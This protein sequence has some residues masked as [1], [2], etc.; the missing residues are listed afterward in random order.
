MNHQPEYPL[1][2]K[3][4]RRALFLLWGLGF[5]INISAQ[6]L[7]TEQ[8]YAMN[9]PGIVKVQAVFSATVYVNKVDLNQSRFDKL[10]DSVKR[11]DSTGRLF[12]SEQ[13]LDILVRA[14]YKNPLRFF[15]PT[16]EYFKQAHRVESS[17]TGF[18]ITGD[19]YILTNCHII[20]R[21]SAYIRRKFILS[22]FHEVSEAGINAL[23]NSWAME[24]NEQ[25]RNLLNDAYGLIYS[26]LSSLILFDLKKEFFVS[27]RADRGGEDAETVQTTA[28]I[29]RQGQPM[30]GK[31]VAILKIN[32]PHE[33]PALQLS[34]D[35]FIA[36]GTQVL[37]LGYPEPVT[38]HSFLA[39]AAAIEPSL[40]TGIVSAVKTSIHGWPVIQ[41]DA[42]ISHGSSGSPVCNDHGEVIGIATFGSIDAG[43]TS[44]ASG[45][46]FAIPVSVVRDF[47]E[48]AGLDPRPGKSTAL[49]NEGLDLYFHQYYRRALEKFRETALVNVKYPQLS[50]YTDQC[51][52]KVES[53]AGH[54]APPR[55]YVLYFM[56]LLGV[57]AV[58]MI[59]YRT[60]KNRKRILHAS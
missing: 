27:Y 40:T 45:F 31:D 50:F 13:K 54:S 57:G 60:R 36:I 30:P 8:N 37:V 43:G 51:V 52:R 24:L 44:L 6:T 12:T 28:Q 22:T 25:Q 29:I 15:T 14:L 32:A 34:R 2:Q 49:Y 35:P 10:V 21:D 9:S 23:Q 56:S 33:L 17:G 42:L 47:L 59:I 4:F 18:L 11:L 26:Q 48:D 1:H 19:G 58:L 3:P 46:N 39:S 41:M 53:G 55:T 5:A 20:D 38:S 16:E 7:G